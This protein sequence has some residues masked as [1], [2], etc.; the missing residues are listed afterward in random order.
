MALSRTAK[1]YRDNPEAR[2]KH[3]KYQS[4]YN[5]TRKSVS[6]ELKII[7]EIVNLEHMVIEMD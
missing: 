7:E 5:K 4:K 2:A 1:F 3:R 6:K